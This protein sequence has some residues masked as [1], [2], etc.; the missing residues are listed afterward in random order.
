MTDQPNNTTHII[1]KHIIF[2]NFISSYKT[3]K[4]ITFPMISRLIIGE[5]C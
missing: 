2:L 5:F 1:P 3:N 4:M